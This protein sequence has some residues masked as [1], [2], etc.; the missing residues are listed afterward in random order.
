M[1]KILIYG[2]GVGGQRLL[3]EM[4]KNSEPYELLAFIDKRIGGTYKDGVPIIF[5]ED[6]GKLEY[7]LIFVATI[8]QTVPEI[9]Q[10]K[11]GVSAE[12]INYTRYLNGVEIS[13]RIRAL[14]RFKEICDIYGIKGSVAEVGVYQGD[15]AKQINRIF[16]ESTLYLYDTFEGFNLSDVNQE[17]NKG[18]VSTYAH[19]ADTNVDLVLGKLPHPEKAVVRKGFFPESATGQDD[20]YAFVNLDADLYAPTLAGLE[21]FYPKLVPG[22]G[23][24]VHDYFAPDFT[25]V[26]KAISEFINR[27]KISISPIGDFRT[28]SITKPF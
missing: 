26:K 15:F 17:E 11:Y 3:D 19:Y 6:I 1:Q 14:E 4:R 2:G 13:V 16:P 24:F 28:V 27:S 12:K 7:D 8:D 21:Y 18:T 20:G 22:G 10:K 25:G 23:I 9:L 5:P